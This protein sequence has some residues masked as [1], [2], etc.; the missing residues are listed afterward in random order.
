MEYVT[1]KRANVYFAAEQKQ[2]IFDILRYYMMLD[3]VHSKHLPISNISV[4]GKTG[5]KY[6]K[7]DFFR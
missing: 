7:G 1:Y 2:I 6:D 5:R 3:Q 4:N